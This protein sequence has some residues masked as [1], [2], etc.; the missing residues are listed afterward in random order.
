MPSDFAI[1][2]KYRERINPPNCDRLDAL[3]QRSNDPDLKPI[4][5]LYSC[6]S[7]AAYQFEVCAAR[8]KGVVRSL[9]PGSDSLVLDPRA[10]L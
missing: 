8:W 9:A 7:P 2:H 5:F 6:Y 4:S 3:Q 10:D 1:L